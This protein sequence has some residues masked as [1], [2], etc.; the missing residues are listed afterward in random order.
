MIEDDD[1]TVVEMDK[2]VQNISNK[3][4]FH[5]RHESPL[6]VAVKKNRPGA[7]RIIHLR[8]RRRNQGS[9]AEGDGSVLR[10]TSLY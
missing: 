4:R 10:L 3:S 8:R 9:L 6:V 5:W 2:V 1:T 7:N